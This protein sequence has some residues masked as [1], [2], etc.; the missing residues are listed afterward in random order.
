MD[1]MNLPKTE[2]DAFAWLEFDRARCTRCGI[3]IDMCPMDVIRFGREGYPFMQYRDD[4]WYCDV[5]TFVCPVRA[6][7][8]ADL[9]YLI[10]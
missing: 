5:C 3:C 9:P 7:K 8:M 10:R 2:E 6:I 4:C 1:A